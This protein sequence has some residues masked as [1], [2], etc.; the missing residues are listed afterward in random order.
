VRKYA[1]EQLTGRRTIFRRACDYGST[2]KRARFFQLQLYG[3]D[4]H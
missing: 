2:W 4:N 1:L 3:F